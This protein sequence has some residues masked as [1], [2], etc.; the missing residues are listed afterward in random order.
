[1]P[2]SALTAAPYSLTMGMHVYIR[3]TAYNAYGDSAVSV[4]GSGAL[5]VYVPDAPTDL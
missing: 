2:L 1:M 5:I 4:V 3:V